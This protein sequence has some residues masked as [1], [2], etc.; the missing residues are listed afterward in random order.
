[1]ADI[2]TEQ[3][4][5]LNRLIDDTFEKVKLN[6]IQTGARIVCGAVLGYA[7]REGTDSEK[8]EKIIRLCKDILGDGGLRG[9]AK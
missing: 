2:T 8:L 3:E 6:S 1:M 9:R 5:Q 7:D 4:E